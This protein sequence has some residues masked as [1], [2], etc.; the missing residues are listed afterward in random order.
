MRFGPLLSLLPSA[1][2]L[3]YAPRNGSSLAPQVLE[4]IITLNSSLTT[5]TT[6]VNVFDGTL[7]HIIPQSLAVVTTETSLDANIL[8]TTFTAKLSGNFTQTESNSV[9]G[10]LAGL[11]APIQ[12]S[13]MALSAKVRF[14]RCGG[15]IHCTELTGGVVRDVQEDA[16]IADRTT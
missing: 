8:K 15:V 16:G 4:Q 12:A 14:V 3:P 2:S 5:L 6:A 9:I 10:G 11:I 1:L 7:L 13:L